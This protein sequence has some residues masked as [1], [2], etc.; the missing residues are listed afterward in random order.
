[1]A[2]HLIEGLC[3][4]AAEEPEAW[5]R[6]LLRHADGLRG[7]ALADDRLF[8]AL[9]DYVPV[10][11]SEGDFPLP[12]IAAHGRLY[13]TA[14]DDSGYELVLHRAL[15]RAVIDGSRYGALAL[16]QRWA[17]ARTSRQGGSAPV[18]IPRR[19]DRGEH[20]PHHDSVV[21]VGTEAGA[22]EM[23][24]PAAVPP[25][26]RARLNRWFARDDTAVVATRFAPTTLPVLLVPNR[27]V[28]LKRRIENDQADR[29][30][31]RGVLGL[32][33]MF[34][35]PIEDGPEATLYVNLDS[36]LVQRLLTVDEAAADAVAAVLLA[37]SDSAGRRNADGVQRDLASALASLESA[38][39]TLLG[40]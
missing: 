23:F 3:T 2:D 5:R 21:I 16:A 7:A 39:L 17:E 20:Q 29:R 10:P 8:H 38:L 37:F 19:G 18:E 13:A 33:R 32:A 34:T 9:G 22:R 31:T 27:D 25:E 4:L 30:M 35:G 28:L 26:D 6:M 15:G 40:G 1:M 24:P 36:P 12:Q 14:G 11:T